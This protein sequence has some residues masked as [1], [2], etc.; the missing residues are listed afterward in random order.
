MS[1]DLHA[2]SANRQRATPLIVPGKRISAPGF[3]YRDEALGSRARVALF[4]ATEVGEGGRFLKQALRQAFPGIEQVD[5]RMREL[6][7][8]EWVFTYDADPEDQRVRITTLTKIGLYIWDP[9][10]P[11]PTLG[12]ISAVQSRRIFDRD[13][14]CTICGIAAG[15]RYAPDDDRTAQLIIQHIVPLSVGGSEDDSNLHVVCLRHSGGQWAAPES[16]EQVQRILTRFDGE[17]DPRAR[18]QFLSWV[19]RGQR[20]FT[21]AEQLWATYQALSPAERES[22]RDELA[23]RLES[24]D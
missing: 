1:S 3:D 24:Q 4:L 21:P 23:R 8:M 17:L 13:R 11:R 22:V 6:R 2:P 14:V 7:S 15:E 12:R 10:V 20:T 18:T 19:L 5:R 9:D 16:R